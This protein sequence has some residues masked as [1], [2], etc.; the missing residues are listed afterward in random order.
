MLPEW[1]GRGAG[2]GLVRWGLRLADEGGLRAWVDASPASL[3]LYKKLG[4]VEVGRLVVELEEWGGK[5][6]EK[7]VTV[8]LI[9]EPRVAK[10]GDLH[11]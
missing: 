8:N 4:W 2:T 7:E 3:G 10:K 1:Q 6:G 9:R 5:V 11:S